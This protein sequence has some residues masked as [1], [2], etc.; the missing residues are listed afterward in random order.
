M[1]RFSIVFILYVLMLT[2]SRLPCHAQNTGSVER[3]DAALDAIVPAGTGID[4]IAGSLK[5]TEGPVWVH[6]GYLLFSDIPAAVIEKWT[7]SGKV[8]AYLGPGEFVGK[9]PAI[10]GVAGTNGLTL[11]KQGR[12]VICDQG[13][14]RIVRVESNGSLTVL[15]DH[16]AGKRL[17]SPNDLVYKLDGALYFTDPPYGLDKEDED[18]RKEQLFNGVYRIANGNVQLVLHDLPRPNGIA[19]SPD[20]KYL[21]VDNS[22]PKKLYLRYEVK[23]D[24]TLGPAV[25]FYDMNSIPG[26]GLPDGMK[27]DQKGNIYGSGPGGIWI[28]SPAGKHLGT[29][30]LPEVAA[31]CAWGDVDG[32][33]L[34]ITASTSVYRIRLKVPGVRP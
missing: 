5:F 4:K 12:L 11:D 16:Y 25:T 8:S 9:S 7:A 28:I 34:F 24:G 29:L 21:Y 6:L 32:R 30:R 18:P 2:S 19:F 17:N 10:A 14:R 22:E 15:A 1:K 13:N 33:S 31:N 26:E 20:E 3:L 27:V 23:A